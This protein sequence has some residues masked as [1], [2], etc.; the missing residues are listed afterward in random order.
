M[1]PGIKLWCQVLALSHQMTLPLK[2]HAG[3]TALAP[4]AV[5][6]ESC[7]VGREPKACPTQY[8]LGMDVSGENC[9][10]YKVEPIT[11]LHSFRRFDHCVWPHTC[12]PPCP[13]GTGHCHRQRGPP[14]SQHW[15]CSTPPHGVVV[16]AV[17]NSSS[18][19]DPAIPQSSSLHLWIIG[20]IESYGLR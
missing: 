5:E 2:A 12:L 8:P 17:L 18:D 15:V 11:Q 20:I 3:R 10:R 1:G 4:P 6:S 13:A 7:R 16:Q 9:P 19:R 14:L